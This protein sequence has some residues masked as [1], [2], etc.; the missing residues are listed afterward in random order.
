MIKIGLV[1]L[2][3]LSII[4]MIG[5]FTKFSYKSTC[6]NLENVGIHMNGY[7]RG[8][9][10]IENFAVL[11]PADINYKMSKH[12]SMRL[13]N[14]NNNINLL[15]KQKL[16]VPQGHSLADD[17]LRSDINSEGPSVDGSSESPKNMFMFAYNRSS[18]YCCPS[19][20]STSTGCICTTDKQ[21]NF[22]NIK[23]GNNKTTNHDNEF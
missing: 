16:Y 17:T 14:C 15:K 6:V 3:C 1:V 18:P 5:I 19:T 21:K 22:L 13:N 10:G 11:N 23:R 7:R 9:S 8:S 12:D 4:L 20:Y 2:V